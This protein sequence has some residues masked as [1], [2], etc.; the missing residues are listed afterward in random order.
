MRSIVC[1]LSCLELN[2]LKFLWKINFAKAVKIVSWIEEKYDHLMLSPVWIIELLFNK[3]CDIKFRF[4][5]SCDNHAISCLTRQIKAHSNLKPPAIRII[6]CY[7]TLHSK[8]DVLVSFVFVYL[9]RIQHCQ[10]DYKCQLC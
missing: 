8:S 2:F 10:T 7:K 1:M 9:F 5:I 6:L 4:I 3:V